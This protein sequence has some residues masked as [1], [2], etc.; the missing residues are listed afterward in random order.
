MAEVE[1]RRHGAEHSIFSRIVIRLG[2]IVAMY[3]VHND[4]NEK[5][6]SEPPIPPHDH[7]TQTGGA[8]TSS[9][10]DGIRVSLY[11]C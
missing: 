9:L 4:N 5:Q 3:D 1:S 7:Y 8:V 10:Q 6:G 11:L 2:D